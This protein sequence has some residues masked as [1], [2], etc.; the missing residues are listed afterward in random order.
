MKGLSRLLF[1][2]TMLLSTMAFAAS[3]ATPL[4]LT[5]EQQKVSYTLGIDIGHN[6]QQSFMQQGV[7]VDP[8]AFTAAIA[9][10][11]NKAIPQMSPQEMQAVM[12]GFQK[13]MQAKSEA[14]ARKIIIANN[15]M[16]FDG[17]SPV[18]GNKKSNITLVEFFD[19][20]CVHCR[21]MAPIIKELMQQD[22]QLRVVYKEFPI[23]G[24][25]SVF[26]STAALAA[27]K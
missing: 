8:A 26:A 7:T 15:S 3:N 23:F 4:K 10:V 16:I 18:V 5:T 24:K 25:G 27:T 17:N 22:P 12:A 13:K 21:R 1:A 19:Y 20:Q 6:I 2:A 9:D 11:L 14:Q